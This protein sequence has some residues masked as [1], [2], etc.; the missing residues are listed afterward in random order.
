MRSALTTRLTVA[1]AAVAVLAG[2]VA[3]AGGAL[4]GGTDLATPVFA[5]DRPTVTAVAPAPAEVSPAVT[6][7][8]WQEVAGTIRRRR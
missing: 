6:T 7:R 8:D 3:L 5:A 4:T 2:G 1:A